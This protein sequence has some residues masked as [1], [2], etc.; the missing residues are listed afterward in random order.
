MSI[1]DRQHP[2]A[3]WS[4]LRVPDEQLTR[5]YAIVSRVND[6]ITER[7]VVT[8]AGLTRFGTVAAGEFVSEERYLSQLASMAPVGW[9]RR[10][11]QVVLGTEVVNGVA[12][13][14]RVLAEWVW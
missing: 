9:E 4:V 13:P 10:N 1:H 3:G 6:S 7:T 12:G 8:V 5:D 14:P 2:D 11:V